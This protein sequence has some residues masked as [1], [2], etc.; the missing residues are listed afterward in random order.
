M[1][2]ACGVHPFWSAADMPIA[3]RPSLLRIAFASLLTAGLLSVGLA[4][5]GVTTTSTSTSRTP[6][7]FVDTVLPGLRIDTYRT[8][9]FGQPQGNS[10]LYYDQIFMAAFVDASVTAG[11][12]D[13][14]AALMS[15]NAGDPLNFL[16]PTLF[17]SSQSL[18]SSTTQNPLKVTQTV[19]VEDSIGAGTILVGDRGLCSGLAN[20]NTV[21]FGCAGGTPLFVPNGDTNINVNTNSQFQFTRTIQT[22]DRYEIFETW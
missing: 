17:G 22:T 20:N 15:A 8:R 16:G 6:D 11:I 4:S 12:A 3:T 14:M 2:H 5:A 21:V 19:Q 13:A 10:T 7:T 9:L 18:L 1:G